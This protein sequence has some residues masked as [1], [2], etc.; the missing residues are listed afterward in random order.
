VYKEQYR[1][2][3]RKK[4]TDWK[5][6]ERTTGALFVLPTNNFVDAPSVISKGWLYEAEGTVAAT[7]PDTLLFLVFFM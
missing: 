4:T 3:A 2:K 7:A 5:I 6:R 1:H